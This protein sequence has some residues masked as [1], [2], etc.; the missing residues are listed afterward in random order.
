MSGIQ[1][2]LAGNVSLCC[3]MGLVGKYPKYVSKYS[4]YVT[5]PHFSCLWRLLATHVA[6]MTLKD[7]LCQSFRK[8]ISNLVFCV[9]RKYLDKPLL[10]MF[11]K[12]MIANI[13]VL[14]PRM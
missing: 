3:D 11:A 12:M 5:N 13:N 2:G 14:G 6:V 10:H 7:I 4:K 9:N 8:C 1:L